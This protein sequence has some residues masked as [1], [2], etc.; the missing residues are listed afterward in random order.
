[1]ASSSRANTKHVTNA[2]GKG[3]LIVKWSDGST[4]PALPQFLLVDSIK[5]EGGRDYFKVLEGPRLGKE[6]SVKR[7]SDGGSYLGTGNPTESAAT[8]KFN[9]TT[10]QL[11]YGDSG[12][13]KATTQ[14]GN[15]A[16]LGLHDI[17]I[18]DE[19]HRMGE[20]YQID[21]P[22]ATTW[23]RV[24]HAGDRYL[25]PGRVSAGCVTVTD[26][27]KWTDVYN[28]LIKRRKGDNKSVGTIEVVE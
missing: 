28:C 2:D 16:P 20:P 1:M 11:W 15:P 12:P 13:I 4:V 26:T 5:T 6:A 9:R 24:G 14:A 3:W 22:F 25:H 7:K 10:G 17:E 23:F 21:S 18:P 8:V 19:V 27:K